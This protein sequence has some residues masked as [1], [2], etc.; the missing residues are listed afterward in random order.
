DFT[1][2]A[3]PISKSRL[4]SAQVFRYTVLQAGAATQG[5]GVGWSYSPFSDGQWEV[6]AKE[7]L[8]GVKSLMDPV[9][10]S[11]IGTMP[12]N[13]YPRAEGVTINTLPNGIVATRKR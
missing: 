9:R 11:I 13:S 10:A 5:P 6:G 3:A 1:V 12:S 2:N 4:T 8:A 7:T